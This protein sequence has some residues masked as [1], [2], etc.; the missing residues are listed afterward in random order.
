MIYAHQK[1]EQWIYES[2][3]VPYDVD[4][5]MPIELTDSGLYEELEEREQINQK[6][7]Y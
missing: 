1:D 2:M 6:L 5:F 3:S 4:K 7:I